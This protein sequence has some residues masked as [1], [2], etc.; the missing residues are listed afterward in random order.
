MRIP[1]HFGFSALCH[2]TR[3]EFREWRVMLTRFVA[4]VFVMIAMLATPDAA[5][6]TSYSL[7]FQINSTHSDAGLHRI[8]YLT[9]DTW[10]PSLEGVDTNRYSYSGGDPINRSD[11]G[12]H[13]YIDVFGSQEQRD[14]FYSKS[15]LDA[16][17]SAHDALSSGNIV[18]AEDLGAV[19]DRTLSRIGASRFNLLADDVLGVAA[20]YMGGRAILGGLSR[21]GAKALAFPEGTGPYGVV[22]GHHV[23]SKAALQGA[24]IYDEKEAFSLGKS[25]LDKY[26]PRTHTLITAHQQRAY[27]SLAKVGIKADIGIHTRIAVEA[28]V[29]GGIPPSEARKLVAIALRD[30]RRQKIANS[31]KTN[32]PWG[33]ARLE[34]SKAAPTTRDQ[35]R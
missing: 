3:G 4:S 19:S 25:F 22:K 27:V 9:P 17:I 16:E 26:G 8:I 11:P 6:A 32:H 30:L 13:E 23:Y 20:T 21:S 28:L 29:A 10:D 31:S 15:A 12:G 33:G 35:D 14:D 7:A 34:P 24:G 5:F 1:R 2:S 18:G